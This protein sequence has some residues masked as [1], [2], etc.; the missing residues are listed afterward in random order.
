MQEKDPSADAA[1]AAAKAMKK[2]SSA[3][4]PVAAAA[5]DGFVPKLKSKKLPARGLKQGSMAAKS[6]RN[7]AA[8][9]PNVPVSQIQSTARYTQ[10]PDQDMP[11]QDSSSAFQEE[12]W[13]VTET[14]LARIRSTDQ[15]AAT[16]STSSGK[17]SNAVLAE[18]ADATEHGSGLLARAS[19]DEDQGQTGPLQ[20]VAPAEHDRA[21]N[22]VLCFELEDAD[23][24]LEGAEHGINAKFGRLKVNYCPAAQ[25]GCI[26]A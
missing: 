5:V 6:T 18:A 21:S 8:S 23:G 19:S 15:H 4:D 20:H 25:Q 2:Q 17:Q 3:G 26:G 9:Q 13:A 24:P 10:L 22:P 12:P 16:E 7:H 14:H 1:F 11:R